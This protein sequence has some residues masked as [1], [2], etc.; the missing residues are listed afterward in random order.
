MSFIQSS[1]K[2]S[3]SYSHFSD[4]THDPLT[5]MYYV[6]YWNYK[7]NGGYST[8]LLLAAAVTVQKYT[9]QEIHGKDDMSCGWS[10]TISMDPL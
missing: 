3:F 8:V 10:E 6:H 2:Y 5:A 7:Q 1:Y 4:Q 9:K